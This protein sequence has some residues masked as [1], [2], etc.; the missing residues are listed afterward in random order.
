MGSENKRIIVEDP[1]VQR[2]HE[3]DSPQSPKNSMWLFKF[4]YYQ[5][6]LLLFINCFFCGLGGRGNLSKDILPLFCNALDK[7]IV[8]RS[9]WILKVLL[10][11]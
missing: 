3:T 4:S 8:S 1:C 2:E 11:C 5:L 10:F 7:L 6:T 9:N